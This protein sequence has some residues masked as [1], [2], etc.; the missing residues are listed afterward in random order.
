MDDIQAFEALKRQ[1]EIEWPVPEP[2][3]EYQRPA[4][5]LEALPQLFQAFAAAIAEQLQLFPDMPALELLAAVSTACAGKVDIQPHEGW[6]EPIQTYTMICMETGERKS[7]ALK[8]AYSPLAA[9]QAEKAKSMAGDIAANQ[10][11]KRLLQKKQQKAE[12]KGDEAAAD[13][14]ARELAEFTD[15]TAPRILADDITPEALATVM[16]GNHGAASIWSSE[17]GLLSILGGRYQNK[18]AGPNIDLILKAYSSD[19][20]MV[21]R[22]GRPYEIISCPA[23]TIMLAVQPDVLQQLMGNPAFMQRGLCGRF[24]F[25][26]PESMVGHRKINGS[27]VPEALRA[28]YSRIIRYLLDI[29]YPESKHLLKLDSDALQ[30]F[31]GWA[32]EIEP[33]L[34]GEWRT[35]G[36]W[37]NKLAGLTLRLAGQLHLAACRSWEVPISGREMAAAIQ[38]GRY[39]VAHALAAFGICA[40]DADVVLA[41]KVLEIIREKRL[42]DFSKRELMRVLRGPK[43]T[44]FDQALQLLDDFGWIC[45]D[46]LSGDDAG[47][48]RPAGMRWI[49]NPA[50]FEGQ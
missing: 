32:G 1:R 15:I 2:F 7:P 41:K 18:D 27:P 36:G 44:A 30:L 35:I 13:T 17:G 45:R 9:W 37:A 43:S 31:D 29:P 47:I 14:Y 22:V 6:Q 28:E 8:L 26:L 5:P 25:S 11:R 49:V 10:S 24:L 20:A 19:T 46:V 23:L 4:F 16:A 50:I 34:A 48:G 42:I 21:D 39:A 33:K 40:A 3:T 38:L 12:E